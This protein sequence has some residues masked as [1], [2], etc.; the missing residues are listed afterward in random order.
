MHTTL[1]TLPFH[2][3]VPLCLLSLSLCPSEKLHYHDKIDM[4]VSENNINSHQFLIALV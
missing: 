4:Q 2:L 1:C 3:F